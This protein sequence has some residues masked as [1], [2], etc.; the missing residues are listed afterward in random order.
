MCNGT[1]QSF[2]CSAYSWKLICRSHLPLPT[3]DN[4]IPFNKRFYFCLTLSLPHSLGDSVESNV[5]GQN[6]DEPSWCILKYEG[7][8]VY[9]KFWM[10]Q[11]LSATGSSQMSTIVGLHVVFQGLLRAIVVI[12][13]LTE[14]LLLN[15]I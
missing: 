6:L 12:I 11:M 3:L 4:H 2:P 10:D 13:Y 7:F 1:V 8:C 9:I 14:F 15:V 5:I